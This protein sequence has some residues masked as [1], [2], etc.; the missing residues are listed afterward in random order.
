MER[1]GGYRNI[2]PYAVLGRVELLVERSDV[3]MSIT[4]VV[5]IAQNNPFV[6]RNFYVF[7]W[8]FA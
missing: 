7:S 8:F 5:I 4:H 3:Q 1:C 6:K 2:Q